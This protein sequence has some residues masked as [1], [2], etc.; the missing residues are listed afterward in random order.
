GM[1]GRR[2][3]EGLD[4]DIRDHIYRETRDNVERGMTADAARVAALRAFGNVTR[5]MEDTRAIWIPVWIDQLV[6]DARYG[7]RMLRS[8]P[9][10]SAVVILTLA[11]GIG[12]STA[13]FS[14]VNAVLVRP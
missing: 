13:A 10:F 11:V 14:V 5:A 4:E 3:L 6:Q 2:S 7:L 12:L 8:T 9:G 1:K